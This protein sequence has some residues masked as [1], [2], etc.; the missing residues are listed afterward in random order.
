ML[1]TVA[2]PVVSVSPSGTKQFVTN[3]TGI[4]IGSFFLTAADLGA[5]VCCR[6]F[7]ET[8]TQHTPLESGG[9]V[10]LENQAL[11]VDAT[12]ITPTREKLTASITI[13]VK[14]QLSLRFARF[15]ND[16]SNPIQSFHRVHPH[17]RHRYRSSISIETGARVAVGAACEADDL[18]AATRYRYQILSSLSSSSSPWRPRVDRCRLI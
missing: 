13:L 2:Q 9:Y 18:R 8:H 14:R 10:L 1:D 5:V 3:A 16:S 15:T 6:S 4:S 17:H 11:S 7:G 12:Y